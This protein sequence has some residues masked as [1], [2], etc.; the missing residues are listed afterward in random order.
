M[1]LDEKLWNIL[2]V[3]INLILKCLEELQLFTNNR[4]LPYLSDHKLGAT[5]SHRQRVFIFKA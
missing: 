3:K 5:K 2:K 4:N 1:I